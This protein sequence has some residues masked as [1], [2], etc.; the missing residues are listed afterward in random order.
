MWPD[1]H[2][3]GVG[4]V[5]IRLTAIRSGRIMSSREGASPEHGRRR[6]R[7]NRLSGFAAGV[8]LMATNGVSV[9]IPEPERRAPS[10]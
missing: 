1:V 5:P 6:L 8:A 4:F 9:L 7:P 10:G 2:V 3:E